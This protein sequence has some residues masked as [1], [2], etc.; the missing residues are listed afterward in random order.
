MGSQTPEEHAGYLVFRNQSVKRGVRIVEVIDLHQQVGLRMFSMTAA[1]RNAYTIWEIKVGASRCRRVSGNCKLE[2]DG[3]HASDTA[4][5]Q[6]MHLVSYL[7]TSVAE[8]R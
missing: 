1:R 8:G 2:T 7:N 4:G 6:A 3:C 5:R